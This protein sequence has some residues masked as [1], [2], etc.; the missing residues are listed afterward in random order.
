MRS[1]LTALACCLTAACLFVPRPRTAL[2]GE[3]PMFIWQKPQPPQSEVVLPPWSAVQAAGRRLTVWGRTYRFNAMGLPRQVASQSRDLLAGSV[4]LKLNGKRLPAGAGELQ[5]QDRRP[6]AATLLGAAQGAGVKVSTRTKVE[7]DGFARTQLTVSPAGSTRIDEL[8]LVVPLRK[9]RARY[10]NFSSDVGDLGAKPWHPGRLARFLIDGRW[11]S[12]FL[13]VL[14]LGDEDVG[15]AWCAES[16]EGWRTAGNATEI[17]VADVGN[18]VETRIHFVQPAGRGPASSKPV[19]VEF[20][21][22]AT[23]AKPRPK[24]WRSWH[25][26]NE[27]NDQ[28]RRKAGNVSILWHSMYSESLGS[29]RPRDPARM[30]QLVSGA[31]RDGYKVIPYIAM[32]DTMADIASEGPYSARMAGGP[33]PA[34]PEL[35]ALGNQWHHSPCVKGWSRGRPNGHWGVRACIR[36]SWADFVLYYIKENIRKYDIDG[37]YF[38]NAAVIRCD[39][40]EHGCGYVGPDGSR[41]V[42]NTLFAHREFL[43]RVY[44]AFTDAG[45]MPI[46]MLHSSTDMVMPSYSFIQAT[47]D[48]EQFNSHWR[49]PHNFE[50]LVALDTFRAHYQGRQFGVAPVFLPSPNFRSEGQCR[51]HLS[52]TLVHDMLLQIGWLKPKPLEKVWDV[53]D[54]FFAA[55][56]DEP[57]EFTGYWENTAVVADNDQVKVSFWTA[58]QKVMMVAANLGRAALEIVALK[59]DRQQLGGVSKLI[60]ALT[61]LPIKHRGGRISLPIGGRSFRLLKWQ[62]SGSTQV[63]DGD[64]P[65]KAAVFTDVPAAGDVDNLG[66]S[67]CRDTSGKG[68]HIRKSLF[69]RSAAGKHGQGVRLMP[70]NGG[71]L[72]APNSD[73]LSVSDQL[74]IE[75]WVWM[76]PKENV[77]DYGRI[78]SKDLST[79]P[80]RNPIGWRAYTLA[81]GPRGDLQFTLSLDGSRFTL[82][83]PPKVVAK[84]KWVHVAAVYDGKQMVL[85]A[86]G[87]ARKR[88]NAKGKIFRAAGHLYIGNSN[89]SSGIRE[90][91]AGKLDEL[92]IWDRART[93]AEIRTDMSTPPAPGAAGLVGCWRFEPP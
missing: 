6:P 55:A 45:K 65:G 61:G 17:E 56:G 20:G 90:Q 43:K 27:T 69:C 24:D 76:D 41:R 48:G 91:W 11:H 79:D 36:S 37:I 42:T 10:L 75:A 44:R 73:S 46:I 66:Q 68:N 53:R 70:G 32:T 49:Y 82:G 19:T 87:A 62:R 86:D 15:L 59:V 92:Y 18:I 12:A 35:K 52:Y 40:A 57:I 5:W 26:V 60:D 67:V 85:Y 50:H 93:A 23:P 83:T 28:R 14:W 58:G 33:L 64:E 31:H 16:T 39:K 7:F 72:L 71:Y 51:E 89:F 54:K 1:S 78:V 4:Y 47:F 2:A 74:T 63:R 8:T 34:P 80:V 3:K 25:F 77:D 81:A 22:M 29:P 38:D 84:G 30:T 21:W 9:D 88:R 13:P